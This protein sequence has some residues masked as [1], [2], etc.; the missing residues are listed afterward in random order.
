MRLMQNE[1]RQEDI[2]MRDGILRGDEAVLEQFYN[3]FFSRLYRYIYYRVGHDH[4]HAEEVIHDTFV[5]A[6]DKIDRF[7]PDRGSM[8]AWLITTS[9]NRIRSSNAKMG[10]A[11]ERES[12]WGMLEGELDTIFADLDAENEQQSAL[13]QEELANFVG[14][15]MG[16][17]P[18]E[19]SRLLE[20]KYITELS[21]REMAQKLRKTEKAVESKLTR[22]RAAFRRMFASI[23]AGEPPPF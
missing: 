8:E 9:R 19:Y 7:D 23:G 22:A 21:T 3:R 5:E 1:K 12:S 16:S 4:H 20:M 2:K 10:R 17:L 15:V 14:L 18:E 13:E 11:H 6:I